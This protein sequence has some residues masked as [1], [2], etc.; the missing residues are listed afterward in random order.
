MPDP[1]LDTITLERD[2]HVLLMGLNRP[3][4]RNAF[5]RAMLTDLSRA[6]G[7]LERDD[8]LRA[9]VLFAH[10]DHFTTG[11]D[12]ADV[13]PAFA[14]G[15]NLVAEDGTDPLR[16]TGRWTTPVVAAAQG[17]TMTVGIEL[18]LAADIRVASADARFSQLEVR[19]GIYPVGGA[20]LRFPRAAGWGDAMRWMLTGD[21]FD[22]A[23]AHRIGIVQEVAE[24]AAGA[25]DRA[26][27]IAR[28]IATSSAPLAVRAT[29]ESAHE[30][31]DAGDDA[32]AAA[33]LPRLQGLFGTAD[34]AEGIQSFVERRDAV[35]TGR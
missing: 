12:L 17:R 10:G 6:Y 22:A 27:T 7:L 31:R 35:F 24:D 28:S 5:D 23:E 8:D 13:A 3:E 16:L 2:G 14:S 11:L 1:T 29:L 30:A 25:I 4:K 19:R 15:E 33:L 20:T 32:A 26:R 34:V 21:T 9:G 18:L